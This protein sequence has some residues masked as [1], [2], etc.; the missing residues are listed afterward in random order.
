MQ[1]LFAYL[2]KSKK[3][4]KLHITEDSFDILGITAS[5]HAKKT[6]KKIHHY[7]ITKKQ[8]I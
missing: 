1:Q 7:L 8:Q 6:S 3:P 4:F 2:Q 5:S